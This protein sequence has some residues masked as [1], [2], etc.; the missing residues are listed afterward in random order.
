MYIPYEIVLSHVLPKCS[1]DTRL[2]FGIK[3]SKIDLTPFETGSLGESLKARY[4]K[5]VPGQQWIEDETHVHI[6]FWPSVKSTDHYPD[7][8]H[9]DMLCECPV[10]LHIGYSY[11]PVQSKRWGRDSLGIRFSKTDLRDCTNPGHTVRISI[12]I[13]NANGHFRHFRR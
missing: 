2:A 1:I 6:P 8:V 9:T 13:I 3:P 7:Y 12:T 11:G 4:N 10:R 5:D